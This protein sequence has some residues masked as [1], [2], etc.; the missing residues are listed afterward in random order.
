MW[1]PSTAVGKAKVDSLDG[2]H[3]SYIHGTISMRKCQSVRQIAFFE[4]QNEC[5]KPDYMP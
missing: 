1:Y 5:R 3:S 2:C 4:P